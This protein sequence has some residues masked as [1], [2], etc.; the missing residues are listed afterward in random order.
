MSVALT[1]H[2][3][4]LGRD[5]SLDRVSR[6]TTSKNG[7]TS[8]DRGVSGVLAT[9]PSCKIPFG[10]AHLLPIRIAGGNG[11]ESGQEGDGISGVLLS[12][13]V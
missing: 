5:I 12:D 2:G 4:R 6:F 1:P 3:L 8:I 9:S 7:D 11:V 10:L 13:G